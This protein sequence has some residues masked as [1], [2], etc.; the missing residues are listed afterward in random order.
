MMISHFNGLEN[1]CEKMLVAFSPFP[2]FFSEGLF[3]MVAKTKQ[4]IVFERVDVRF[5]WSWMKSE[6]R[7]NG[8]LFIWMYL[9]FSGNWSEWKYRY[10]ILLEI[11][12]C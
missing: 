7:V 10:S 4:G 9:I 12:V 6:S 11:Y 2:T 5:K 8:V 3:V 1:I